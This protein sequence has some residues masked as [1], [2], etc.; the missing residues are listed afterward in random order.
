M[1]EVRAGFREIEHTADW[2]LQVWAPT[3]PA[4]LEQAARGALALAG[5][6]PEEN[7]SQEEVTFVV[8]GPDP[9]TA[10]VEFLTEVLYRAQYEGQV[11][12]AYQLAWDGEKVRA[13]MTCAPRRTLE[14]EIKAVTYHGLQ[15]VQRPG[16]WEATVVFDV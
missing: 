7:G 12:V 6:T 5:I 2:A 14:K 1:T 10:L 16:R 13:R 15:V 11:P 3:F 9:E 8:P 4:L